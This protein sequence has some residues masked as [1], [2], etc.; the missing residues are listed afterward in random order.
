MAWFERL[1][2]LFDLGGLKIDFSRF[3]N[4]TI[5][6]NP[7]VVPPVEH[8]ENPPSLTINIARLSPSHI[9]RVG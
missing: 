4:I 1:K 7:T 9:Q 8:T 3:F 6:N 2:T 5:I